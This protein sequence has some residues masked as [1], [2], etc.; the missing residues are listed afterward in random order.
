MNYAE[1]LEHMFK[2]DMLNEKGLKDYIKQLKQENN[3]LRI[4]IIDLENE[5]QA[6]KYKR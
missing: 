5:I 1:S 3:E 4:K 6:V 2:V